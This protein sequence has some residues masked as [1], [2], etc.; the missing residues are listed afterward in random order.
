MPRSRWTR[1]LTGLIASQ[2]P[3]GDQEM[4]RAAPVHWKI[5]RSAP[6]SGGTMTSRPCVV[7]AVVDVP[8]GTC[9]SAMDVPSGDHDG[10]MCPLSSSVSCSGVPPPMVCAKTSYPRPPSRSQVNATW[11]PSGENVGKLSDPGSA[12]SGTGENE[13]GGGRCGHHQSTAAAIASRG[14]GRRDDGREVHAAEDAGAAPD[15]IRSPASSCSSSSAVLI[16][17]AL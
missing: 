6:P 16:S 5:S 2:R 14:D 15:A 12:V 8:R 17:D 1:T 13:V 7:I 11:L 4:R 3:S 9:H 10:Y